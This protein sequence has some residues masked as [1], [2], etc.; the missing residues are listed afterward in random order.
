MVKVYEILKDGRRYSSWWPA[1]E[2]SE[3]IT[4]GRVRSIVRARLPYTLTF[5]T[6][7]IEEKPPHEF[8][9]RAA[10]ELAGTGRWVLRQDGEET[11]IVFYWDVRADKPLIR[12][13][14]PL[15]KPLFRWNHDWVMKVGE[16]GLQEEITRNTPDLNE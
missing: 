2:V 7:V 1:Y 12:W 3:E 15:L 5:T 11:R 9:I 8:S 14:S 10:G 4:H 13:L 6:E 16:R